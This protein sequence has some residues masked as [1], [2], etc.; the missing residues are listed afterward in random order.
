MVQTKLFSG[1]QN[2]DLPVGVT[3]DLV[4]L[5]ERCRWRRYDD[6]FIEGY[7]KNRWRRQIK[8]KMYKLDAMNKCGDRN[9]RSCRGITCE[10]DTHD[11]SPGNGPPGCTV[12]KKGTSLHSADG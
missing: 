2:V 11:N 4:N 9:T 6:V 5:A 10:P 7:A 3:D 12:R 1:R 8:T